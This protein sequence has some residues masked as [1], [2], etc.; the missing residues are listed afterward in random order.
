[1]SRA[2]P[3]VIE[4]DEDDVVLIKA[5]AKPK[6]KIQLIL[7]LSDYKEE[8][9][10]LVSTDEF[11]GKYA[12][13]AMGN[14]CDFGRKTSRLYRDYKLAIRYVTGKLELSWEDDGIDEKE[15]ELVN[16]DFD[17]LPKA[18][19]RKITHFKI[20]G[21]RDADRVSRA[22]PARVREHFKGARCVVCGNGS[23]EID[24]KNGLYNFPKGYT[25]GVED[26]QPLCTHCN[27][28]KRQSIVRTKE[29]GKRYKATN[30]PMV[31]VLRVDFTQ[32][33][34]SYD[35]SDPNAMVG[36][37]WYD[38]VDFTRKAIEQKLGKFVSLLVARSGISCEEIMQIWK[39][40][41]E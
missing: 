41:Q 6:S 21:R 37:Y 27:Q 30:I 34:E 8:G 24:H 15:R 36:T 25:F 5:G 1:M 35:P 17:S 23:I 26:F 2:H 19:G 20:Y 14:G 22:I 4:D 13:L 32:G 11:V 12:R 38:P 33:D 9:S 39:L 18:G 31:E 7:E 40:S 16:R 29:T 3:I 28:Q 10:R